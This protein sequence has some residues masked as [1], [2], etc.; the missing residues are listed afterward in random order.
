[1]CA[2]HSRRPLRVLTCHTHGVGV[3]TACLKVPVGVYEVS[4]RNGHVELVGVGVWPRLLQRQDSLAAELEELLRGREVCQSTILKTPVRRQ[5]T[6][7]SICSSISCFFLETFS[8]YSVRSYSV[9][10]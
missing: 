4:E 6:F 8:P 7:G 9:R 2:N 5:L 1:M 3:V 10:L